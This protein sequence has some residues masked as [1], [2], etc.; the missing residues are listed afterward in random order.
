MKLLELYN[1]LSGLFLAIAFALF[2]LLTL[3][4]YELLILF[5]KL[6]YDTIGFYTIE[7]LILSLD[8]D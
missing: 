3:D 8:F 7:M 6:F 5:K 2:F 4:V 1:D